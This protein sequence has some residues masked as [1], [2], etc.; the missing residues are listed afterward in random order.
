MAT[1]IHPSALVHPN[2]QLGEGV[3]IGPWCLVDAGAVLE[4]DVVLECRVHVYGGT[5]IGARTRVFDGAVLGG[6]PQDLKY[7]QEPTRLEIG[8]DCLLREYCTLH[9]GTGDGGCTQI[10]DRVLVMAYAHVAHDCVLESGAVLANRV[11]LGG[12]VRIGAFTTIGGAAAVQQFCHIGAYSFIGGTLKVEHDVPPASRA[13]G[14]PVRWA[15]LNLHALRRQN[16]SPERI[17]A[18]E[19][20]YRQ[21]F[22]SGVPLQQAVRSLLENMETDALL[23]D[24]FCDWKSGLVSPEKSR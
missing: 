20:A 9:R 17:H 15:G 21:L 22:R 24:F 4:P 23:R 2:A 1:W 14:D 6:D 3:R 13:L 16:F 12:H 18:L 11:Q 10:S 7:R 19:S 5:H 8:S